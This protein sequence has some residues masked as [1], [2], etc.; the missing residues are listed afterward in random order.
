MLQTVTVDEFIATNQL[1][2]D[3]PIF[4]DIETEEL[5]YHTSLMQLGNLDGNI[6]MVAIHNDENEQRMLEF[7]KPLHLVGYNLSYDLGTLNFSPKDLD[8]LF[9]AVKI[10][11]PVFGEFSLDKVAMKFA[12]NL[13]DGLDKKQLQ[14]AGFTRG[15]Y[16]SQAQLRYAQA[17]IEVLR[18]IWQ[19]CKIQSVI[20]NNLAYRLGKYALLEAMEW[21]NNGI[22]VLQDKVE[23]HLAKEREKEAKA[24]QGIELYA[25]K[26]INPRSS[27]QVKEFFNSSS[28]DEATLVKIALEGEKDGISY[29]ENQMRVAEAILN[30][31]KAK[32]MI[33]KLTQYQGKGKMYGRFNPMGARTSR[34]A[35]KG[36]QKNSKRRELFN[37]Q[38]FPR[39][40]KSCFGVPEDSGKCIVA[41]DYATLEIRI[42]AC[43]MGEENM[44][45]ALKDGADIHK[46]TAS[47][48]FNKPID[49][50]HGKERSNS[51]VANF[52]LSY[53]MSVNTFISYAYSLYGIKYTLDEAKQIVN[54]FFKAYP[55]LKKYH[56]MMAKNIRKNNFIEYTALDYPIKPNGY[57]EAI[58]APTQGTGAEC[59]RLAIHMMFKK[60]KRAKDVIINSIHDALYLL[61]NVE[62]LDYWK[63][64]LKEA[65]QEA[66]YEIRKSR[67]F[68]WHDVPMPVDVE[69]G[70]N[71]D[72]MGE[73]LDEL[74]SHEFSGGGQ[75]LTLEE[76]R[77]QKKRNE[78]AV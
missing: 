31:R 74:H 26:P 15:A 27:K 58:N 46:A 29:D 68:K 5:Y 1:D 76:M 69:V 9:Y 61:V 34:W 43:I 54:A 78:D 18:V 53:G 42:A 7:L 48:I 3:K 17:D 59:M 22:P 2:I 75:N 70:Y 25:G 4:F 33:G 56:N 77:E 6:Y 28:S 52:G 67:H 36:S 65:M 20:S 21:Q 66:W 45:K 51:K 14:K 8:D 47:L 50:I 72:E 40:L 63:Q 10:A 39:Q 23:E 32:N 44:Y 11:Y 41:A 12:S 35:C 57:T 13:Y 19:N 49:Q 62:E 38:N 30:A 55:S 37:A 16:Y 60:D 24:M 64:T 73:S 71:L